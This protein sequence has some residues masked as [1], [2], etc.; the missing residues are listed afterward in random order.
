MS[1]SRGTV[2][3]QVFTWSDACTTCEAAGNVGDK[4][5]I[6]IRRDQHI[7]LLGMAHELHACILGRDRSRQVRAC[8]LVLAS[9]TFLPCGSGRQC[10][11]GW[12]D[13]TVLTY[14]SILRKHAGG[15]VRPFSDR[16]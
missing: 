5:T 7:K 13:H 9:A 12:H 6:Q 14:S 16:H 15:Q 2:G 3:L 10:S 11:A 4:V 8:R 1:C